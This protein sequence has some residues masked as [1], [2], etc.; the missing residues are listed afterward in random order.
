MEPTIYKPSIYKGAGIYKSGGEGGGGETSYKGV[1]TTDDCI[2]TDGKYLSGFYGDYSH[3]ALI[4]GL[5]LNAKSVT[6]EICVNFNGMGQEYS[7]AVFGPSVTNHQMFS[8]Q[9]NAGAKQIWFAAPNSSN[10]GWQTAGWISYELAF[11]MYHK[12]RLE[13]IK[14]TNTLNGYVNDTLITTFTL[15]EVPNVPQNTLK[16]GM[17]YGTSFPL[18]GIIDLSKSYIEADGVRQ[19]N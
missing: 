12:L 4:L 13:Y 17:N 8:I 6:I 11:G 10:N 9:Y 14:D 2:L 7:Q 18:N 5:S 19:F 15:S 1:I 3:V 16:L